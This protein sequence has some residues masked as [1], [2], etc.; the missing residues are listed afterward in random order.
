VQI[1]KDK[2]KRRE[3][4]IKCYGKEFH[5]LSYYLPEEKQYVGIYVDI[6]AV[7]MNEVKLQAMRDK[8]LK[9]VQKLLNHQVEMAQQMTKFLG[10]STA[11][12]EALMEGLLDDE[13]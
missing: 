2:A 4:V 5:Q 6:S 13:S 9:Q 3:S 11:K 1:V 12:S 8:T 7:R 10:E